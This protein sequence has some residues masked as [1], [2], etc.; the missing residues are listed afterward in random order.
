MS[1][2]HNKHS[3]LHYKQALNDSSG[4]VTQSVVVFVLFCFVSKKD[5]PKYPTDFWK[6]IL[7]TFFF[8]SVK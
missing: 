3:P 1:R 5:I 2:R 8:F 4:A 6:T 7:C